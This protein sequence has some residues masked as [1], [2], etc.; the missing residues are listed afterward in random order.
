MV[1]QLD[2][3]AEDNSCRQYALFYLGR[4]A[5]AFDWMQ[6]MLEKD[7]KGNYY[8]AA[9]LYSLAGKGEEAV[10][11]LRKAFETGYRRFAHVER[12]RD[13]KSIRTLDSYK[14][15]MEEYQS[16]HL[17]ETVQED[18]DYVERVVEVPFTR[19]A[20][21]T[22]VKCSINGLPLS[23]IF[24][25]GASTV[26]ISSLEAT[27]MYKNDYLTEKDIVGRSAFVDANGDISVGTVINLKNVS[28]G[29]LELTDIKASVVSNDQAP[30]LLGQSVLSRLGR[31]EIDYERNVLKITTKE[32]K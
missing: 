15:L 27:F 12:D 26:S 8:D 31:I 10:G 18:A 30:L 2:T 3:L 19:S 6:K 23:F 25:T 22:K 17:T 13:L 11:F 4:E 1:L 32:K 29:G 7:K 14:S 16:R 5:E 20:G 21:V 9:C 24:D 28:F